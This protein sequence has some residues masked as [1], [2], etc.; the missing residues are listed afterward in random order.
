MSLSKTQ[1]SSIQEDQ[2]V[3]GEN[4]SVAKTAKIDPVVEAV[5][6]LAGGVTLAIRGSQ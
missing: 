6:S 4:F 5:D 2:S 1:M 3:D